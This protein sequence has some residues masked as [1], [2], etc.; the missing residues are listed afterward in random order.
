MIAAKQPGRVL[1]Y[2]QTSRL[3]SKSAGQVSPW[4]RRGQ[5]REPR[6]DWCDQH[7]LRCTGSLLSRATS[8]RPLT[9]SSPFDQSNHSTTLGTEQD[10]TEKHRS[11]RRRPLRFVPLKPAVDVAPKARKFFIQLLKQPPRPSIC[12]I[13]LNYK[14][15]ASGEPRMV[16]SFEFVTREQLTDVDEAIPLELDDDNDDKERKSKH[17]ESNPDTLPK[18]YV[19]GSAFLKVLGSTVDVDKNFLPILY[20]REGNRMDPNA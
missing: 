14:Q 8:A 17:S 10:S 13:R 20:D 15:A 11:R 6:C 2:Q 19:S 1:T 7:I 16:F 4:F 9:S 3:Y 12:G 5:R 18:L